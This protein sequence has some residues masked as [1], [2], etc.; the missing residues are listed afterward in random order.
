MARTKK[1][2]ALCVLQSIAPIT[3]R[4]DSKSTTANENFA[5]DIAKISSVHGY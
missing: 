2:I 4:F 5:E 3:F 1:D